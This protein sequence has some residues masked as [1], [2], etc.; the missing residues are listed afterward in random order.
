ME[1]LDWKSPI[2]R[3]STEQ[4]S[5]LKEVKHERSKIA[6]RMRS[7]TQRMENPASREEYENLQREMTRLT[8]DVNTVN[9]RF[10]AVMDSAGLSDDDVNDLPAELS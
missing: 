9:E 3:L 5:I 4:V 6:D 2:A 7:I 8:N 1:E 10:W